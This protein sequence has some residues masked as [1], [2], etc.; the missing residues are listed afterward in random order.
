MFFPQGLG[1]PWFPRWL[2]E[3]CFHHGLLFQFFL[4]E[5]IALELLPMFLLGQENHSHAHTCCG[6]FPLLTTRSPN[7]SYNNIFN[8]TSM[9]GYKGIQTC[10]D[11]ERETKKKNV[12]FSSCTPNIITKSSCQVTPQELQG[13]PFL[14]EPMTQCNARMWNLWKLSGFFRTRALQNNRFQTCESL[15]VDM[16]IPVSWI[17]SWGHCLKP[18]SQLVTLVTDGKLFQMIWHN[19]GAQSPMVMAQISFKKK[20]QP[21]WPDTKWQS[22][23]QR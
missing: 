20:Q 14:V 12:L 7:I 22:Q 15:S 21:D 16:K 4:S 6:S 8:T 11:R 17:H 13:F 10:R 2:L 18:S 19:I 23:C 9:M 1:P 3:S 5:D